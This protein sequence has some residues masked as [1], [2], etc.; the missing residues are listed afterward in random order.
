M[1]KLAIALAT[2]I[3]VFSFFNSDVLGEDITKR[4]VVQGV[5]VDINDNGNYIVTLE[6]I[7]TENYSNSEGAASPVMNVNSFEGK[8][9]YS[10]IK[11]AYSSFGKLPLLSQNRVIIIGESL[12]KEGVISA[13]DFF[14][15][16]AENYPSVLVA[17]VKMSAKDFFG[18]ASTDSSV[19]SRDVENIILTANDDLTVSSI[20]LC[21][22]VNRYKDITSSFYMPILDVQ[23][24]D[25]KPIVVSKGT[26]IFK[27]GKYVSSLNESET[28]T[29]NFLC[30]NAKNGALD[31]NVDGNSVALS[32]IESSTVRTVNWSGDN[33]VFNIK[34]KVK[35]DIAEMSNG[36]NTTISSKTMEQITK[37]AEE[38]IKEN[39]EKLY[40]ELINDY[41]TDAIGISRLAYIRFPKKFKKAN[42]NANEILANSQVNIGVEF[43]I[44]RVGQDYSA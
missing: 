12:A 9:V 13:L 31:L 36:T 23:K 29:L 27:K 33:P 42:E 17:T 43:N 11:S 21:E 4:T 32:V 15:R 18:K 26:A 14:I 40:S 22:L 20:T 1:R 35:A 28:A 41:E 2:L 16:D 39:T 19:V 30:N 7:N 44:R 24:D 34:I 8:T 25:S 10:A 3:C 37:S 6:T 5:G 38:K